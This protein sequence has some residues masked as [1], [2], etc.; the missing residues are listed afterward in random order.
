MLLLYKL[1]YNL[2]G[3]KLCVVANWFMRPVNQVLAKICQECSFFSETISKQHNESRIQL[4]LETLDFIKAGQV[5]NNM[6]L[7]WFGCLLN[8]KL[9]KWYFQD[10]KAEVCW[11]RNFQHDWPAEHMTRKET[12]KGTRKRLQM[13]RLFVVKR[14]GVRELALQGAVFGHLALS[15][16]HTCKK[17]P[18]FR[19]WLLFIS[20]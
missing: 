19:A 3:D 2:E 14:E 5:Y 11:N 16:G 10:Q 7:L 18:N 6:S 8:F 20:N 9:L 13:L 1:E 15:T 4:K 12:R 17:F